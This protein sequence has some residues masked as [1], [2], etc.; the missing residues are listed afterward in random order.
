MYVMIDSNRL[1]RRRR[2]DC[3]VLRRHPVTDTTPPPNVRVFLFAAADF[4]RRIRFHI[5]EI[6]FHTSLPSVVE[7]YPNCRFST[8][9]VSRSSHHVRCPRRP[10][11]LLETSFL[12]NAFTHNQLYSF[13]SYLGTDL[14]FARSFLRLVCTS[15]VRIGMNAI[16]VL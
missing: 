10:Y 12:S 11:A 5:S 4:H 9:I 2:V 13:S 6:S 15:D 3:L 7:A 1:N 16:R 8:I 14:L